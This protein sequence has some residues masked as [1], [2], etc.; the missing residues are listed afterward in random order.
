[1]CF[2]FF[3]VLS[4][5]EFK[6]FVGIEKLVKISVGEDLSDGMWYYVMVGVICKEFWLKLDFKL[7]F[8]YEN[9]LLD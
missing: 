7:K 5:F 6:I 8:C 3:L 4:R 2:Y 1:M 9:F